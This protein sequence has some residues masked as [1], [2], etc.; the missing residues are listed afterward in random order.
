M[1]GRVEKMALSEESSRISKDEHHNVLCGYP[2][3]GARIVH[4]F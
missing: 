3:T 2:T 4:Q 1:D